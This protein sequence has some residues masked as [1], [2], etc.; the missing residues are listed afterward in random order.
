MSLYTINPNHQLRFIY[1]LTRAEQSSFKPQHSSKLGYAVAIARQGAERGSTRNRH[2][3]LEIHPICQ[4]LDPST[5]TPGHRSASRLGFSALVSPLT[6]GGQLHRASWKPRILVILISPLYPASGRDEVI[7]PGALYVS[8]PRVSSPSKDRLGA[9]SR[10]RRETSTDDSDTIGIRKSPTT[11][12]GRK[13]LHCGDNCVTQDGI[14]Y[15]M[16]CLRPQSLI[17]LLTL[18]P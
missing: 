6:E 18:S 8:K 15:C 14:D 16:N 13:M 7:F 2:T 11:L 12:F 10:Q 5:P 9:Q 4:Q 17:G 3:R 1:E